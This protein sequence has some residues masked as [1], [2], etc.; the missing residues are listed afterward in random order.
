M[1]YVKSMLIQLFAEKTY[2]IL[3]QSVV[4]YSC[5][6]GEHGR[7]AES[8]KARKRAGGKENMKVNAEEVKMVMD[9]IEGKKARNVTH[10]AFATLNQ[11]VVIVK[12]DDVLESM[13]HNAEKLLDSGNGVHIK[14]LTYIESGM[15]CKNVAAYAMLR[16]GIAY[17]VENLKGWTATEIATAKIINGKRIGGL[18]NH[19]ADAINSRLHIKVE[20]KALHGWMD[21]TPSDEDF[22]PMEE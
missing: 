17:K 7:P 3:C 18:N 2:C 20:V 14:K 9:Y 10:F 22:I 4:L 11:Y 8:V 12:I 21:G 5:S 6:E 15:S 19:A 1:P 13:K 16:K